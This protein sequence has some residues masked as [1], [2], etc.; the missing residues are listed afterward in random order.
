MALS[1]LT[2]LRAIG[3]PT[4]IQDFSAKADA[5]VGAHEPGRITHL[6]LCGVPSQ[7]W[8]FT[9]KTAAAP[10]GG[11]GVQSRLLTMIGVGG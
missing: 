2:V 4:K 10:G 8:T 11:G 5:S 6:R 3:T 7:R 1:C 9:A